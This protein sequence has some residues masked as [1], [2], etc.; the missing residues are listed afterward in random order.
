MYPPAFRS[1]SPWRNSHFGGH[2][3]FHRPAPYLAAMTLHEFNDLPYERQ[4]VLVF[5]QARF[6]ATH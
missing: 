6:L 2:P 4:V 3:R 1:P 5:D